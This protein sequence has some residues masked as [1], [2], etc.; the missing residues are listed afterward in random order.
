MGYGADGAIETSDDG[1]NPWGSR[2]SGATGFTLNGITFG[3]NLFLSV[4]SSGKLIKS[5]DNGSSWSNIN[6]Q[7]STTLNSIA[8]G[9]SIFLAVGSNTVIA[10]SDN[11]GSTFGIKSTEYTFEDVTY[12][13]GVFVAVGYKIIYTSTDGDSWTKVY[14]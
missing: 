13:N 6:S 3:N 8:Y 5:T 2:T 4:G 11:T 7:V 14:P 9:N 10:S 1:D 12:G